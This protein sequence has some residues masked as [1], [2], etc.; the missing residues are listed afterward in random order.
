[1][2]PQHEPTRSRT[3]RGAARAL[4]HPRVLLP[5]LTASVVLA[6]GG[7]VFLEEGPGGEGP[8]FVRR[9]TVQYRVGGDAATGDVT[10]SADGTRDV[11]LLRKTSLPWSRTLTVREGSRTVYQVSVSATTAAPTT[12]TCEIVLDGEPVARSRQAGP[13]ATAACEF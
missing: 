13:A 1:M 9:H 11:T 10:F 2:T 6:V 8:T 5:V 12:V 3:V 4:R 7:W